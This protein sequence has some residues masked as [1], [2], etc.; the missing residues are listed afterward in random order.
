MRSSTH[1]SE[2]PLLKGSKYIK[3]VVFIGVF[4][5]ALG[6]AYIPVNKIYQQGVI[7]FLFL[8]LVFMIIF[9]FKIL[10]RFLLQYK[11]FSFTCGA[12]FL[13]ITINGLAFNDMQNTKHILYV[14]VFLTLGFFATLFEYNENLL[15]RSLDFI[16]ISVT[17]ICLYSFYNFFYLGGNNLFSRMWGVLGVNQPILA[18]YYIGFFFILSSVFFTEKH[19][20]YM[21]SFIVVFSAFI[22]FAQSR[23]AY[24]AIIITMI[25][26]LALFARRN[27]L[28]LWW[29]FAFLCFSFLLGY[30]FLDQIMSR[31]TSSRPE[32]IIAGISMAIEN[33]WF[34]HGVGYKYMLYTD[35]APYEHYHAHNLILHIFIRLG[36]VGV[37]LFSALWVYCLYYCYKNKSIF[38]AKF[39]VLLIIFSSVAFQF[40]AAYFITQPRLAWFVVWVPICIT[41]AVM[42]LRFLDSVETSDKA[43]LTSME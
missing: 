14:A 28:A 32:L 36:V 37:A 38:L 30:L 18:S 26:Y 1:Q 29:S 22:L 12:L 21:F 27:K 35:T 4:W 10:A 39:N 3:W 17:V 31:G 41:V 33:L 25:F 19:K 8:P 7:V 11:I 9:N 23:G 13:Y 42:T 34:G 16:L 40:D 15:K 2:L 43:Q 6:V 24:A 20:L 5:F